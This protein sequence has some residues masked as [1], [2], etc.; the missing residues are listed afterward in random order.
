MIIK[1]VEQIWHVL[2]Q[3]PIKSRSYDYKNDIKKVA[4]NKTEFNMLIMHVM[5]KTFKIICTRKYYNN[6]VIVNENL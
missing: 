5:R 6:I 1:T 2:Q 3:W 4:W